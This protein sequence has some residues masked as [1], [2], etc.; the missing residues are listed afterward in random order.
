MNLQI[1]DSVHGYD[2]GNGQPSDPVPAADESAL[3]NMRILAVD[4][5][6]WLLM[7]LERTLERAGYKHIELTSDPLR[8]IEIAL[9]HPPDLILLDLHMPEMSGFELMRRLGPLTD[10]GATIPFLM[11]TGD[12]GEDTKRRALE[13]GARDLISKPFDQTELL[14]RVRN[15]LHVRHLQCRLDERNVTLEHEVA[16]RTREVE[17]AHLEIL[18]RLAVAAEYRDDATQEHAWRIGRMCAVLAENVG[19][20]EEEVELY[21]RAAPLHDI[22]KIGI[23]D[24]ILLKPGPLDDDER[25]CMRNH[26]LIGAEIL[27]HGESPVLRLAERIAL[28]HHERWDGAGYIAGLT[29]DQIPLAGRLTAIADVFDALTHERPY[30]EAMAVD[31]AIAEIELQAGR[32]F[33]PTLVQAFLDVDHAA[34]ARDRTDHVQIRGLD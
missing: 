14:L 30:K 23:P 27:S 33:D 10:N 5:Q 16:E 34:L 15:L 31:D 20:P 32:Q 25:R 4:D 7:L 28:S 29:G 11:L 3:R 6:S 12:S 13:A 2:N 24:S 8:A 1:S 17:R 19:L 9:E 18:D 21:R 22:G 26:V